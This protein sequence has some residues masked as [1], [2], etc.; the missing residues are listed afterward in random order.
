LVEP[1]LEV[2]C[3]FA[4][5]HI[6]SGDIDPTYPVLK[7]VYEI[8]KLDPETALWRTLLYVTWYNL[9]SASKV[10]TAAWPSPPEDPERLHISSF[11]QMATGTERRGFRGNDLAWR[12]LHAVLS[13]VR[14][15]G[16]G[17]KAWVD[18]VTHS[19]GKTGWSAMRGAFQDFPYG[20]N[21]SSYKWVDLLKHVHSYPIT[22]DD[23]GVGGGG[24]TAGPIPGMVRVTGCDWK[25]CAQDIVLQQ[26]LHDECVRR[27]VPFNGLDQL[28]TALCDFN[29]LC[30][31]SYYV[32]HDIDH[33]M[34]Q[35]KEMGPV[36]WEAR[37][38]CF[39]TRYLGEQGGWFG[40]RP[41]LKTLYRERGEL[42]T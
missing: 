19:G 4:K 13:H 35:F 42:V 8:E 16:G 7:R 15:R 9:G 28:E 6:E 32:G 24:A 22:A 21:W 5:A 34:E 39:P 33:Q 30:K 2:F 18:Y 11:M 1:V 20:G 10:W 17:L 12:H 37:V 36:W 3:R 25:R 26:E 29:S 40:V 27:G 38:A 31:G 14:T 23:I 41:K